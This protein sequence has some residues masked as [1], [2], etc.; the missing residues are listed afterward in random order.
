[1][2]FYILATALLVS[3]TAYG[4]AK[5]QDAD[6]KSNAAINATKIANGLVSNTEFQYLDGVTS[7]IQTQLNTL[8][9]NSVTSLSIATANGFSGSSSGGTTPSL[10][11]GT[12]ITGL[13]KGNGTAISAAVADTDYQSPIST[14]G[15]VANQF[16]TGFTAPNTFTRAQ[17]AFTDISGTA[18]VAQGGTGQTTYSDGQLLIGNSATSGLTKATLTAGANI[19]ITN[20]NGSITIASTGGGGGGTLTVSTKT[21]NY[22]MTNSDDVILCDTSSGALTITMQSAASATSKAYKVKVIGNN[23]CTIDAAG[24]DTID[25][26]ADL[27]LTVKNTAVDLISDGGTAWYVF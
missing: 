14:S 25:G 2:K 16:V 22:T 21:A 12:T 10:T 7:S 8:T 26:D 15:A 4:A 13:L 3:V 5:I 19:T 23:A 1:M 20:G 17:P 27:V 6:I 24:A 11:I 18:A 9:S